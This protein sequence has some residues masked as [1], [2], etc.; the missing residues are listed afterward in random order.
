ASPSSPPSR[1]ASTARLSSS[2]CTSR[3]RG[4]WRRSTSRGRCSG[5][6]SSA[7]RPQAWRR[8]TGTCTAWSS[9]ARSPPACGPISGRSSSA[10]RPSA[11]WR[12]SSAMWLYV[13]CWSG[14]ARPRP[15]ARP[16]ECLWLSLPA[17][18]GDAIAFA[19]GDPDD[20]RPGRAGTHLVPHTVRRPHVADH[21]RLEQLALSVHDVPQ[22]AFE[23][24]EVLDRTVRVL[25]RVGVG[26][27]R[28]LAH[29]RFLSTQGALVDEHAQPCARRTHPVR[30]LVRRLA[31]HPTAQ[32]S[33]RGSEDEDETALSV[34]RRSPRVRARSTGPRI[35][36][37]RVVG[38]RGDGW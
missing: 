27:E 17:P 34:H 35:K 7:S 26:G 36:L 1:S 21:A 20:E 4:R 30:A 31:E 16:R 23:D 5:A 37:T 25:P 19:S 38:G 12:G 9:T 22:L 13:S 15:G 32:A 33:D 29:F 3:T 14:S 8:S 18:R 10:I 28:D 6:P 24:T 11:C 2:A